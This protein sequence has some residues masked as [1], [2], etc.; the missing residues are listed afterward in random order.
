MDRRETLKLL[1]AAP[2][3][4]VTGAMP[5]APPN[6]KPDFFTE[7]EMELVTALADLII[8]ADARSGSA[9]D[10]GVPE[11]IDF[12][13]TD[14]PE[15][16]TPMRGGLA[17]LNAY[18]Q[19]QGGSIFMELARD[20][21][22]EILDTLAWPENAPDELSAGVAFFNSFRDLVASGFWSSKMGVEDLQYQGN[23]YVQKWTGCPTEVLER[24]G[25]EDM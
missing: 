7:Q 12:M 15:Y 18:S 11:F 22:R 9:S 2:F 25:V 10:A 8:P 24:L 16:Q 20:T 6:Y 19:K 13:M 14:R 21:Q 23:V 17:W 1:A 3:F 4:T 5:V